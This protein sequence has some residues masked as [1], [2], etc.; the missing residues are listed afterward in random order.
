MVDV[1]KAKADAHQLYQAGEL[2]DLVH[3]I[4]YCNLFHVLVFYS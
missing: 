3:L 2:I 1:Q 4:I